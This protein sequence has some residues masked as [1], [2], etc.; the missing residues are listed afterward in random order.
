MEYSS[1]YKIIEEDI[2][3]LYLGNLKTVE[4][5][6]TLPSGGPNGSNIVWKS[7]VPNIVDNRGKVNRPAPGRG[8]RTVT[9][10][11][12][13]SYGQAV[14]QKEFSVTVLEESGADKIKEVLPLSVQ[15]EPGTDC[16]LPAYGIACLENEDVITKEIHWDMNRE[17]YVES[18]G[19]QVF[20]GQMESGGTVRVKIEARK[21]ILSKNTW[22]K[23]QLFCA[24][25][26]EGC[27][28]MLTE[29]S[30]MYRAQQHMLDYVLQLSEDQMLY[31]F[32]TAAGLD[33]ADAEPM[34]GWD[35]PDS[36]LRGH[37]TGHYLSALSLCYRT[38]KR[39]D[40]L[41]K[42]KYMINELKKC[43]QAFSQSGRASAGFLSGYDEAQFE[44]LEAYTTYPE[45]WAPYYTLHKILAGLLDCYRWCGI[46][47]ALEIAA[48]LGDWVHG[49]LSTLPRIQLEKMWSIYIAGEYGGMNESMVKLYSYTGKERYLRTARLFDN[50]RLFLPLQMN[51]DALSKLHANQHIPQMVGAMQIFVETGCEKYYNISRTFWRFVTQGHL[52]INGGTG[53]AEMFHKKG[54]VSALITDRTTESCATYNMLKLTRMLYEYEPLV[55]YMDY[56]ERA[57]FNHI[58]PSLDKESSG[59]STYFFPLAPGGKRVFEREN[60]CCHGTGMESHFRY[61]EG[62]YF[63]GEEGLYINLFLQSKI[64]WEEQGMELVQQV[65]QEEPGMVHLEVTAHTHKRRTG[66]FSIR[67]R[68]PWWCDGHYEVKI[69]GKAVQIPAQNGYLLFGAEVFE[70]EQTEI[71]IQFACRLHIEPS[72]DDHGTVGLSWGPYVLAA[73]SPSREYLTIEKDNLAGT[74]V[75][76]KNTLSFRGNGLLLE[77]LYKMDREP[78]HVYFHVK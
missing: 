23:P 68:I 76:D 77:P 27:R 52:Y 65:C 67:C 5:D 69:R 55:M 73:K 19:S 33:T 17:Q 64:A 38:F 36:L 43:Q 24:A 15:A 75:K 26:L 4:F 20:E 32:R 22:Q 7:A 63:C 28:V 14:M 47:D 70:Q 61:M 8:S 41:K 74:F 1:D 18:E 49:R 46:I 31:N 60:S 16:W 78:Y 45:I 40:I 66:T 29:G 21:T 10:T 9:L 72:P 37:T 59:E 48:K 30:E 6:L 12:E 2:K 51:V 54:K 57:L 71:D 62:V 13:F 3:S 56:Y 58:L 44:Q 25:D 53:E 34:T 50:E 35:A 39:D 11:A 42:A